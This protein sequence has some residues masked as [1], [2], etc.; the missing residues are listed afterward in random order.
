M[1]IP[2]AT[3]S[4][5]DRSTPSLLE[6]SRPPN[7][8]WREIFGGNEEAVEAQGDATLAASSSSSA[9]T[10]Y[11]DL[12]LL[13]RRS[14]SVTGGQEEGEGW[15]E[16]EEGEGWEGQEEGEEALGAGGW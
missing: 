15:V 5:S 8:F 11:H 9:V 13:D 6:S 4:A 10:K 1:S 2:S 3:S 16:Q 7:E 12:R 14:R